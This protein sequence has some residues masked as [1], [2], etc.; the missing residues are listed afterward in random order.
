MD[1]NWEDWREALVRFATVTG[2]SVSAYDERIDR[3]A[4]PFT[5]SK[6]TRLLAESHVWDEGRPGWRLERDLAERVLASGVVQHDGIFDELHVRA[7]PIILAG[8][9]A[10]VITYGW[11]F[12][13][14]GTALGCERLARSLGVD[15]ARLWAEA[16]LEPP[17]SA[18]R[19]AVFQDL[20]ETLIESASRH[21][22]A[23]ERLNELSR[24]REI[25]LAQVSHELRTPLTALSQRIELMLR[26]PLDD[27]ESVRDALLRM[28]RHVDEEARLVEDLIDASRTRTGQLSIEL[29]PCSL[30]EIL[31]AALA[32]VRPNAESKGV[33][34]EASALE[35]A[36][37][38]PVL[39]D[40]HRLQQVFWN[41]LSNAVKFTPPEGRILIE[42]GIDLENYV[43]KIMDTGRGI[44]ATM[45]PSIFELFAR[46][47][48]GNEQGLGLGLSIAL[49][50]VESHG[51]TIRAE[52]P[53]PGEGATFRVVLPRAP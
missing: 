40:K 47:R 45:L 19:M 26:R 2:L 32:S 43:V 6:V 41:L 44:D 49:H 42:L 3:Q 38:L 14:F 22:D 53:G 1:V 5:A 17:I 11:A 10:G 15:G 35:D 28:K 25:F 12:S 4:G 36:G 16:R 21:A 24:M 33:A 50:I 31:H 34:I 29:L 7:T 20:L 37:S 18:A 51:G 13:T 52:S 9:V 30:N 48:R 8:R 23:I 27:R 39:A 46:Q